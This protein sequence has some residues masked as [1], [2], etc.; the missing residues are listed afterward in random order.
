MGLI[1]HPKLEI[2]FDE[3]IKIPNCEEKTRSYI[4]GIFSSSLDRDFTNESLTFALKDAYEKM[5][6]QSFKELGDYLFFTKSLFPE[7]LTG[8]NPGYYNSIAQTSYYKCFLLLNRQW[9]IYEELADQFPKYTQT[10][11]QLLNS[12]NRG[13]S[14]A[15]RFNCFLEIKSH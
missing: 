7:N 10:V 2:F 9:T 13:F 4:V 6:F 3:T 11:N 14:G 15:L 12:T 8:A 1:N 5:S